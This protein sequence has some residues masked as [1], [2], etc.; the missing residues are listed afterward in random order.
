MAGNVAIC[1]AHGMRT[2][3]N[4]RS[5]PSRTNAGSVVLPPTAEV[6]MSAAASAVPVISQSQFLTHW[7]AHRRLTRR[8]IAAFPD[9]RLFTSTIR[10]GSTTSTRS[11]SA[12]TGRRRTAPTA[13]PRPASCRSA[14]CSCSYSLRSPV[15]I[16]APGPDGDPMPRTMRA[17]AMQGTPTTLLFDARGRLRRQVFGIHDDLLLGAEIGTLLVEAEQRTDAAAA[18]ATSVADRC[19]DRRC[20]LE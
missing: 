15:G 1:T 18:V 8:I 14:T 16:D 17:Y 6:S 12:T 2:A 5:L 3:R 13:Q 19:T 4:I 11:A 20:T 10:S 9:D 7:Q